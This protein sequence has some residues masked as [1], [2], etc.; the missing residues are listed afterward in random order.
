MIDLLRG[1]YEKD[2]RLKNQSRNSERRRQ[3]FV[4]YSR[5]AHRLYDI[6]VRNVLYD[7]FVRKGFYTFG[8]IPNTGTLPPSA[9]ADHKNRGTNPSPTASMRPANGAPT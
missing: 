1:C 3:D 8:R 2:T 7:I 4:S 6:F 9:A 5:Q